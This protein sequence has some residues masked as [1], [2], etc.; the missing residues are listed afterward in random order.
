MNGIFRAGAIAAAVLLTTIATHAASTPRTPPPR[1]TPGP[2]EFD[3]LAKATLELLQS[4]D[5][6]RFASNVTATAADWQ[7]ITTMKPAATDEDP[8]KGRE[9]RAEYERKKIEASAKV[10][11]DKARALKLDFS[12][13]KWKADAQAPKPIGSTHYQGLQAEGETI[14]WAELVEVTVLPDTADAAQAAKKEFK[15]AVRGMFKF[16]GGW[17]CYDGIQWSSFPNGV[18]NAE[19]RME[20]ALLGLVAAHKPIHGT[21]DPALLK[22]GESLVR[23]LRAQ[24]PAIYQHDVQVTPDLIWEEMQRSGRQGPSRKE[25]DEEM[26]QRGEETLAEAQ[27]VLSFM[28]ENGIDF[29]NADIRISDVMV[30]NAQAAGASPG[31]LEG[32][33]GSRFKLY[34]MVRTDA[35]AKNGASLTGEYILSARELMRFGKEWRVAD[36]LHWHQLPQLVLSPETREKMRTDS[37]IADHGILPAGLPAPDIEFVTLADGKK[38]KLSD[39]RGKVVVLDFWATWCGP[40]QQPMADLQKAGAAH[41]AWADKVVLAPI[42]IDDTMDAVRK[43]VDKRGWTNTFNVWAGEGG[44]RAPAAKTYSVKGV[45]TTYIIKADGNIDAAGHPAG[46]RIEERVD[47]LLK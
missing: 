39:L 3:A 33:M 36:E 5:A 42:S 9:K 44:W 28:K 17:R 21:N 35:K 11:V 6:A 29:K 23:F 47:A 4:G 2:Q 8:A 46:L 15:L 22:L 31:S 20:L 32:L 1:Y 14:P 34:L 43:H 30:D 40:C 25:F 16:P 26:A 27:E 18:A 24:D 10:V 45:P 19:T 13:G 38:M 7:A 37:Y 41:P 12:K